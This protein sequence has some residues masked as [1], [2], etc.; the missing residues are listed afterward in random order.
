MAVGGLNFIAIVVAAVAAWL[1]GA[2]WYMALGKPWIAAQGWH[3]R[4]EMLRGREKPSPVPFI[5][6]FIAELVMAWVLAGI[7]GHIAPGG[8]TI[9][10]GL[11]SGAF[12]C[13]GFVA[14]TIAVNYSFSGRKPML[15]A[16]DAG[17]WLVVLL[18]M[19]AILGGFGV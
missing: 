3:S 13:L 6:S 16:I 17:H 19:G 12:V 2:A 18:V 4:A 5:V 9:R 7:L 1:A 14:T 15:M 8:T 10:I 11:I